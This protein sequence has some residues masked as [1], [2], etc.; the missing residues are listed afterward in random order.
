MGLVLMEE[1]ARRTLLVGTAATAHPGTQAPT[2]KRGLTD[3]AATPVLTVR[4]V[5]T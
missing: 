3:A 2:V 5:V 4:T 1:P